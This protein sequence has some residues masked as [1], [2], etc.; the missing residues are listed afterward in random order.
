MI[1]RASTCGLF[2]GLALL[3]LS[4]AAVATPTVTF[5]LQAVPIPGFPHTGD[6][7]GAGAEVKFEY[8]IT[9]SEYFGSAPPLI[10]AKRRLPTED[11]SDL[12]RKRRTVETGA[13]DRV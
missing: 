9:G 1:C 4:G 7:L 2:V 3:V 6:I 8:V 5:K 10:G 12:C 13:G 11:R